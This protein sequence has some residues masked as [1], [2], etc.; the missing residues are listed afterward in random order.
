MIASGICLMGGCFAQNEDASMADAYWPCAA[1]LI[2]R[3]AASIGIYQHEYVPSGMLLDGCKVFTRQ[4]AIGGHASL[5][6]I[7]QGGNIA[8]NVYISYPGGG[9]TPSI[10]LQYRSS[11][12][13][14]LLRNTFPSGFPWNCEVE[15]YGEGAIV[16]INDAPALSS[17]AVEWNTNA[18]G[19]PLRILDSRNGEK[20]FN[21]ASGTWGVRW[22]VLPMCSLL[23]T[24]AVFDFEAKTLVEI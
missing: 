22:Y 19:G 9:N 6:Y 14:K 17:S 11:G 23:K 16:R 7:L 10:D 21:V 2:P 20:L 5:F 12:E 24:E 3:T 15:V 8:C 4:M 18:S 1:I 13:T